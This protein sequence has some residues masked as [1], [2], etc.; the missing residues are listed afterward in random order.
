MQGGA[1]APPCPPL[2][3]PMA[4]STNHVYLRA[5]IRV[6]FGRMYF[7]FSAFTL[8]TISRVFPRVYT[9]Y[10]QKMPNDYDL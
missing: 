5:E 4:A 3:T 7:T 2:P 10:R 9:R 8:K 1:M 6:S